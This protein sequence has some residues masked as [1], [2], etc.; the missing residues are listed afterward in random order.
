MWSKL[1]IT[2]CPLDLL[3]VVMV[4]SPSVFQCYSLILAMYLLFQ[5][6]SLGTTQQRV[7]EGQ[8]LCV[9]KGLPDISDKSLGYRSCDFPWS[10][11]S[12]A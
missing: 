6:F 7:L 1:W 10:A 9:V 3:S 12:E 11:C 4:R 8:M 2:C 5:P